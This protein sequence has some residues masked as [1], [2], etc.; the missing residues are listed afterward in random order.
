MREI[1]A[2]KRKMKPSMSILIEDDFMI[3]EV[4]MCFSSFSDVKSNIIMVEN[5]EDLKDLMLWETFDKNV[6]DFTMEDAKK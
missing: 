1:L 2:T 5:L 3:E 4:G 6:E